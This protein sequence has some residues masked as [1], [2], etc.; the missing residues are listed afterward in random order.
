MPNTR[1][2][3]TGMTRIEALE[4][5]L[6]TLRD[7]A[8]ATDRQ[9]IDAVLAVPTQVGDFFPPKGSKLY[10][11]E[12]LTIEGRSVQREVFINHLHGRVALYKNL[13]EVTKQTS[14]YRPCNCGFSGELLKERCGTDQAAF[15]VRCPGCNK[16]VQAFTEIGLPQ[17]WNAVNRKHTPLPAEFVTAPD[18]DP[19]PQM[20]DRRPFGSLPGCDQPL[21][22]LESD[23]D[24]SSN[25]PEA[26]GWLADNHAAIRSELGIA[27][28]VRRIAQSECDLAALL[29]DELQDCEAQRDGLY[30]HVSQLK[31][32]QLTGGSVDAA[33]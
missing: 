7:T 24:W 25:D 3:D 6:R 5:A 14:T 30:D 26:V 33:E 2:W 9:A 22:Y 13:Y 28:K 16:S 23:D 19:M 15:A 31:N 1:P 18:L 10:D 20:T 12:T 27:N 32:V 17:N 21:D 11:G 8:N 29:W 4:N